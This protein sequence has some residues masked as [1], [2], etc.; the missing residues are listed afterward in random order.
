VVEHVHGWLKFCYL[1]E[2]L[3]R[4]SL[5]CSVCDAKVQS[6]NLVDITYLFE[7]GALID[8]TPDELISLLK[9]LFADSEKR[10]K[11]IE[12]IERGL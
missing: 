7:N 6:A 11:A 3:V 10:E 2:L 4:S 8:F 1:S 9:A 5:A 12:R